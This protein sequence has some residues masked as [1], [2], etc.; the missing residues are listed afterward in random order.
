MEDLA[1]DKKVNFS[2]MLLGCKLA[3]VCQAVLLQ[4]CCSVSTTDSATRL[5]LKLRLLLFSKL[6]QDDYT[7][8]DWSQTS[9]GD[10]VRL[11]DIYAIEHRGSRRLKN[12]NLSK[13]NKIQAQSIAQK[14][15]QNSVT[16]HSGQESM[17]FL[18]GKSTYVPRK[19]IQKSFF[20][21]FVDKDV[22]DI[23]ERCCCYS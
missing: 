8:K 2:L 22:A 10:D 4:S 13:L 11:L 21:V 20:D 16:K 12:A 19:M 3:R 5:R 15:L 17:A 6:S 7:P 23:V 1:T 9:G 14:L 18:G